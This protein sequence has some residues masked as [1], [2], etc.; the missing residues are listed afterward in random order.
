MGSKDISNIFEALWDSGVTTGCHPL[1]RH[2]SVWNVTGNT[3]GQLLGFQDV[4][5]VP[6]CVCSSFACWG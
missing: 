4:G 2:I 1:L 5:A 3:V 6:C